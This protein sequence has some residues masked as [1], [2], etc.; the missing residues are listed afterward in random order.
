MEKETFIEIIKQHRSLIYKICHSYCSDPT[1]RKDLEQE[2]FLQLWKSMG[3]FD[4]RVKISTWMYKVALNTAIMFYRNHSR[5]RVNRS[6]WDHSL[7]SIQNE[8]KD[9]A[10]E[11]QISLL[12][13]FINQLNDNEKALILLYLD[14]IKQKEIAEILGITETNVS[15]KISRIKKKLKDR[16]KLFK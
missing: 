14:G 11:E 13:R 8:E 12:Y 3:R 9:E 7:L 1:D 15:S 6:F 4:G 2:I 5:H 10:Y 16:V